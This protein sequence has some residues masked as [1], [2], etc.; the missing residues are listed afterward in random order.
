MRVRIR[1]FLH[2]WLGIT[3]SVGTIN[4]TIHESGRAVMPV[5]EILIEVALKSGL[6]NI[7]ET[8]WPQKERLL[9]LGVFVSTTVVL[10][11][12][13]R[14]TAAIFQALIIKNVYLGW[15][16]TDGYQVY[17]EQTKRLRC[18]A[19]LIRKARGLEEAL[20][21][22]AQYFG[23][24]SLF[25]L[26][27]LIA[28]IKQAREAPP[29]QALSITYKQQIEEYQRLC[30]KMSLSEHKKTHALSVEMLNN[31][32]VIFTVLD[33]PHLPLTNNEAERT[34]RHWVILRKICYGT[35]TDEGSRVFAILARVIETCRIRQC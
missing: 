3:L 12:V 4:K 25:L 6:L 2:D 15:I 32:A 22:E 8:S 27:S 26:N 23:E 19:H 31:W 10:F 35:R 14:R 5:E 11:R 24:K 7:D 21:S 9:W 29:A 28:A 1:E 16:M 33:H 18:W 13:G 20:N 34:L 30:E 17:R